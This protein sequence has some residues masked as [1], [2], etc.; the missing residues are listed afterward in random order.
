MNIEE[1]RDRL[2]AIHDEAVGAHDLVHL[3]HS[4]ATGA[5][6]FNEQALDTLH[7]TLARVLAS[8]RQHI[9]ASRIPDPNAETIDRPEQ[10]FFARN[11]PVLVGWAPDLA[12]CLVGR[13]EAV[14][15]ALQRDQYRDQRATPMALWSIEGDL[16]MLINMIGHVDRLLE[17]EATAS[18]RNA[19]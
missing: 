9:S 10:L 4:A 1:T 11:L 12:T 16:D 3:L 2:S 19:A 5:A 15:T 13:A 14:A 18:G 8:L 7:A 17:S 6:H